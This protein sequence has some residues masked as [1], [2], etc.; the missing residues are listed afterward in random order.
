M[1]G[2]SDEKIYIILMEKSEDERFLE[3]PGYR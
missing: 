3:R 2:A 1:G